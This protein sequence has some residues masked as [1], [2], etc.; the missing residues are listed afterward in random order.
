MK[1][2]TKSYLIL[3][4]LFVCLVL[5][6]AFTNIYSLSSPSSLIANKTGEEKYPSK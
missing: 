3:V 1:H 2:T 4:A 5:S 6:F